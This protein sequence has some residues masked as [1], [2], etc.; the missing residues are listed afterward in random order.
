MI[1]LE[2]ILGQGRRQHGIGLIINFLEIPSHQFFENLLKTFVFWHK[3]I[4]DTAIEIR[5]Q[6]VTKQTL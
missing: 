4:L 2:P 5:L 3:Y 1:L 6:T